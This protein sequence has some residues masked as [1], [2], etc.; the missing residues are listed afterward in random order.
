M[1]VA[2][3]FLYARALYRIRPPDA[4]DI[5]TKKRHIFRRQG[6]Q[7]MKRERIAA[8]CRRR[9]SYYITL[10]FPDTMTAPHA[11]VDLLAYKAS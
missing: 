3:H 7:K 1:A 4:T 5:D 6:F 11:E 10:R 9:R 2:A 8:T